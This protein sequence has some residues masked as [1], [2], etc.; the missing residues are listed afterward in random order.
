MRDGGGE[1]GGWRVVLYKPYDQKEQEYTG[2][3]K[4]AALQRWL[5]L[6]ALPVLADFSEHPELEP[7]F[8]E[9]ELPFLYLFVDKSASASGFE[10]VHDWAALKA[11]TQLSSK[12]SGKY[13]VVSLDLSE[14]ERL[15]FP[16]TSSLVNLS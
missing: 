10:S 12:Y 2:D 1:N 5:L 3:L 14:K 8:R 9:R 13:S 7:K 6:N 16:T 15:F 11:A 4:A